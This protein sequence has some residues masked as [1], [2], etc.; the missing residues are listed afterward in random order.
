MSCRGSRNHNNHFLRYLNNDNTCQLGRWKE[1]VQRSVV[2]AKW[3]LSH[4]MMSR[5]VRA[6][7]SSRETVRRKE[8]RLQLGQSLKLSRVPTIHSS[9]NSTST[10]HRDC[11]GT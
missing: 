8:Q 5:S 4:E 1:N 2:S 3:S 9:H 10:L 6:V 7:E 11:L